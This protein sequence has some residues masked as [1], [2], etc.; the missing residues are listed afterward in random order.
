MK[1][2]FYRN[3]IIICLLIVSNMLIAQEQLHNVQF[4]W[5]NK[6]PFP[7]QEDMSY[8]KGVVDIMVHRS[9]TD[10]Y[11]FLHDAAIV[12]HKNIL[13][14]AWYNCPS[15]EMQESSII[16]GRRSTDYGLTWSDVEIIASDKEKKGIMYVPVVFLSHKGILYAFISNMEGGPDL[17]TR[18]EVFVLNEKNN[19]W[20]SSGF[21][22]GPF[23][24]NSAPVE[25]KNGNFIMAGRMANKSGEKPTIPAVAISHDDKFTEQWDVVP[26]NYNGRLPSGENPDFPETTVIV[27]GANIIAFVRNHSQYPILFTSDDYGRTWSDPQVHNFPFASSKIYAGTLSTG[28]NYVLSNIVSKGYR[29]LL[30]IAVSH[31]GEKQ[32]S[33]VWKIR[34]GYFNKLEVGPEWSYPSAIEYAEKLY[35]VYTSEKRNCCLTIIP[36]SSLKID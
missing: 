19:S 36:I 9:E 2:N 1:V 18:C 33:K 22:T 25:M 10:N 14:A 8:P 5:N 17:V 3:K 15:R 12:E 28:Q 26:L 6:L 4:V 32:F 11:N 29:D 24:P 23:L 16:R 30:T 21:I 35:I 34:Y 27:D 31:S 7:S 20:N 13:F